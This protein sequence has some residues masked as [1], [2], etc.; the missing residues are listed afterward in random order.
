MKKICFLIG[1]LNNSGGT[2]RVTTLIANALAEKKYQVSILSLADGKQPFFELV[3]S[4]KTYSLYPEKISFKKNFL[5]AVWRIRKFVTQH[6][7]D[8]LIVVDSISCIFTV[9]ALCGLKV[10]H[11][12]WE[13]FNFKNNNGVKFRDYGRK[14]AA[15]Y[16][17]YVVTLTQRDKELWEKG[18]KKINAKIVAIA[19]PVSYE[20]I[21]NIPSLEYKTVLAVGRLT[22]VKG[23]DLLITAWSKIARQVPG[24]KVIIVG[25]GEDELM[26]K[27]MAK[28]FAVEDSIVFAGQQKDMDQFYRQ[29]SFFCMSSRFE[30]FAMVLIEAQSYGLP[31]VAFD[32]DTGPAEIICEKSG[33]LVENLN[34]QLLANQLLMMTKMSVNQY[35]SM[36]GSA[37]L[38]SKSYYIDNIVHHWVGLLESK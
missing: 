19:N 13:H 10:K 23:Y 16:C 11:I 36:S 1:N 18:L 9:P 20:D 32:C 33:I 27:Q 35:S 29:A 6:Q 38:N 17:D 2:E 4:I 22:H 15:K 12:C 25:S 5:G 31:I 34:V 28:D 37:I 24:W 26:L 14:L 3:P 8:T 7:I 21:E 30:G